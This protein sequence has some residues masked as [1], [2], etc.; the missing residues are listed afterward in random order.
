[1]SANQS[2]ALTV[3]HNTVVNNYHIYNSLFLQL[4][5]NDVYETG[6]LLPILSKACQ[7]GYQKGKSPF[8]I[9]SRFF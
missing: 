3:F 9:L 2:R 8:Q 5:F 4:P 1:M 7:K 6:V